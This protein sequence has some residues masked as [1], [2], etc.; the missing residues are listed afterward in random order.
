MQ[1]LLRPEICDEE[2]LSG[3]IQRVVRLNQYKTS[4]GLCKLLKSSHI[5]IHNN[6]LN[7][8]STVFLARLT[9]NDFGR[10]ISRSYRNWLEDQEYGSKHLLRDKIKFCPLCL[11][12]KGIHKYK[13]G[14]HPV[15]ICLDH[16]QIL[17]DHCSNCREKINLYDLLQRG[18][19]KGCGFTFTSTNEH[20]IES[21]S[22]Y[23]DSQIKIQQ[24]LFNEVPVLN[25]IGGLDVEHFFRLAEVSFHILE[26]LQSFI[27]NE[28]IKI[29]SFQNK[30]K[31]SLDNIR[32]LVSWGNVIWMYQDFP[33]HYYIVLSEFSRKNKKTM[34]EQ[35]IR[36]ELGLTIKEFTMIKSAYDK[37]W[38]QQLNE[39]RIR[40]DFSIFKQNEKLLQLRESL[41]REEVKK[42]T[43]M[44][45]DKLN[46]LQKV[47]SL[48]MESNPMGEHQK[49]IVNR[50]SLTQLLKDREGY[51]HK[52]EAAS[53][54]GLQRESV[55]NLVNGGILKEY[56]TPYAS[57]KLLKKREVEDILNDCCGHYDLFFKGIKFHDALIKYSVNGL[58]IIDLI[59]FTKEGVIH[60][61]TREI[62]GTLADVL[63]SKSEL[64][65]CLGLLKNEFHNKNG[66]YLT[67][68]LKMLHIGEKKLKSLLKEKAIVPDKTIL[69]KD[70]RKRYLFSQIQFQIL[71]EIMEA[72]AN[73]R[74]RFMDIAE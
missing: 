71:Q 60:P 52:K 38:I 58:K 8:K 26:G 32:H 27:D 54:L 69:L 63:Y 47:G 7:E 16:H 73:R 9:N 57:Y 33:N 10:L 13:W 19:C 17:I 55:L 2:S 44:S 14:F 68:L 15:C 37:F 25:E 74:R 31:G 30:R 22:M 46:Q 41:R 40:R 65:T 6:L 20:W 11:K 12:Q 36:Y 43:G 48:D 24:L 4:F 66:Y 23:V 50:T 39:G 56:A 49:Y 70:G 64:D 42:E 3:Y 53:L 59:Y 1:F 29:G 72:N 21:D 61:R 67:D 45:Y 34:Y 35:K 51:I 18:A 62:G 5:D 28:P